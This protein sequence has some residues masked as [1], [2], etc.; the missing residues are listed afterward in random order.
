VSY[1]RVFLCPEETA[2]ARWARGLAARTAANAVKDLKM[3][4][5]RKCPLPIS[6]DMSAGPFNLAF[7]RRELANFLRFRA[8][9]IQHIRSIVY[10]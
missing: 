1:P 3:K 8:A 6:G 5:R 9:Y 7:I 2:P 10:G 4:R